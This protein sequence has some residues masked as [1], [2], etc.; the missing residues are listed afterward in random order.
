MFY[1]LIVS[2]RQQNFAVKGTHSSNATKIILKYYYN[3]TLIH[4]PI[5]SIEL[6]GVIDCSS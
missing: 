2:V 5:L 3:Y 1:I 6:G 4:P